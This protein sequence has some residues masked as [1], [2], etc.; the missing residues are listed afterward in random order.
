M[1]WLPLDTSNGI[2][3]HMNTKR[4]MT[5]IIVN[6]GAREIIFD[7]TAYRDVT[8]TSKHCDSFY[9]WNGKKDKK[10]MEEMAL[11]GMPAYGYILGS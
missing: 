4:Q 8:S 6:L 5:D 3:E 11:S 9:Y 2:N 10:H 1:P 7:T